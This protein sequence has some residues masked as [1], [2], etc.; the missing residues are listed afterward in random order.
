MLLHRTGSALEILQ[1]IHLGAEGFVLAPGNLYLGS[2]YEMIGSSK[3]VMTLLG[4]SSIGRLGLFLNITAD[5]GHAGSFSCWTLEMTV[6]QPLRVYPYMRVG[7]VAF[8]AQSGSGD[9]YRGRYYGD[10]A[11]SPNRDR[12]LTE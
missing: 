3:F 7:Q 11:P 10:R 6:V 2:T 12:E 5:L 1:E 8:W 4:R 9:S